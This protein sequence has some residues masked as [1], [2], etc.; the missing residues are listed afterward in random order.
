MKI[1]QVYD[2]ADKQRTYKEYCG[3]Y[4]KAIN[5][6][7]YFEAMMIA[8]SMI[9]DRLKSFLYHIGAFD[10][11]TD[12]KICKKVHQYLKNI[13]KDYRKPKENE[14]LNISTISGKIKIIRCTLNWAAT[15]NGGY[16]ED[17]YLIAL[18]SQYE[19]AF[20]IDEFLDVLDEIDKWREYRNEVIHA[21]LNKNIESLKEELMI[22]TEYGM[23]LARK[24]DSYR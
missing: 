3:K 18:K 8:Y 11:R 14:K 17:K 6:K 21:L 22:Q 5:E 15:V 10:R 4:R 13:V 1:H 9:E 20:D 16:D 7:F 2:N 12:T 23:Q 19:G 24:L